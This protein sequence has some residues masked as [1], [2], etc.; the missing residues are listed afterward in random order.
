MF[1]IWCLFLIEC[2]DTQSK[3]KNCCPCIALW[4]VFLDINATKIENQAK[5]IESIWTTIHFLASYG[6][7]SLRNLK[8]PIELD[9]FSGGFL[10]LLLLTPNLLIQYI[11]VSHQHKDHLWLK[12]DVARTISQC[13]KYQSCNAKTQN[14]CTLYYWWHIH[15]GPILEWISCLC[16]PSQLNKDRA[17]FW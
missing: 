2:W 10:T 15:L 11:V 9:C 4:I 14:T 12:S 7:L 3:G 16:W 1:L 17:L 5:I 8:R 6:L 13:C